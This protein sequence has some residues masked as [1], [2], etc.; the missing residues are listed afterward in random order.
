M[1]IFRT[2]S[3]WHWK[4]FE[5]AETKVLTDRPTPEELD[6]L[7][8]YITAA[9]SKDFEGHAEDSIGKVPENTIGFRV[10]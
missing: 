10:G 5:K 6:D 7:C 1:S 9:M 4:A 2:K 8:S 3:Q